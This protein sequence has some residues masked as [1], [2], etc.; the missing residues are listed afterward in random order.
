MA[1]NLPLDSEVRWKGK[2]IPDLLR[3]LYNVNHESKVADQIRVAIQAKN[4]ER[5]ASSLD[6]LTAATIRSAEE[7]GKLN[8]KVFWLNVLLALF[9]IAGSA[10]AG[11]QVYLMLKSK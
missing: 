3:D 10:F 1:E 8:A 5:V 9:T 4:A 2:S 11:M 6:A 7:S